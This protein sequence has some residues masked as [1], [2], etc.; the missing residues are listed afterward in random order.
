M[1]P[2]IIYKLYAWFFSDPTVDEWL[3]GKSNLPSVVDRLLLAIA[4]R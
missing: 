1:G 4:E 2:Y 3:S